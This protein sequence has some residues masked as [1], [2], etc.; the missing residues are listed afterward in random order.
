MGV[1]VSDITA[2]VALQMDLD[3]RRGVLIGRVWPNSPAQDAGIQT[4]D[5]LINIDGHDIASLRELQRVMR[6]ELEVG[7]EA[8]AVFLREGQPV[9]LLVELGEMP[10]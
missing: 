2:P 4:G 5:I 9:E 8:L 7:Q 1:G 10:R 6:E 3:D